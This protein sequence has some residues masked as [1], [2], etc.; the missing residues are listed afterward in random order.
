MGGLGIITA[1]LLAALALWQG[2]A[3]LRGWGSHPAPW[4]LP[5]PRPIIV[6]HR[7]GAG[8][9]PENTLEAF[10]AAAR[11][12]GVR[13]M[14]IDVH[15]TADGVP[16]VLHD[17][18]V[19]RTTDG[20]GAVAAMPLD[21][22]QALDAG[23]GFIPPAGAANPWVGRG[24]RIPTLAQ[25]L[26]AL[27]DCWFSI[28]VKDAAPGTVAAVLEVVRQCGMG[29]RAVVGAESWRVYRRMHRLAPELPSFYCR[30]SVV[31]FVLAANLGLM[32]WYRPPHHTLQLP[33]RFAGLRLIS[34]RTVRA[35]H[36]AG[37]P[38]IVWTINDPRDM[39]RLLALGVDGL[40]TDRPDE[41]ARLIGGGQGAGEGRPLPPA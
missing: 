32:R 6:A 13:F 3:L 41:M 7:G 40:I 34:P 29:E 17:P 23:H 16:V 31:G 39:Q 24:V 1:V 11:E 12:H 8:L 21:A 33:E 15:G 9:Y 30:R 10:Q 14:E 25:V 28:D 18:T 2:L 38:L 22:V 35:A 19:A 27:P 37:L 26:R 20:A 4:R 5:L 36:R